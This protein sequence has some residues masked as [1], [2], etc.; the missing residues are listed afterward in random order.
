MGRHTRRII[1]RFR[2][3]YIIRHGRFRVFDND[4]T[5]KNARAMAYSKWNRGKEVG[6]SEK[7]RKGKKVEASD[8]RESADL[9]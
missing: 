8:C 2:R 1:I 9:G 7:E 4:L 3:G 5:E 6:D